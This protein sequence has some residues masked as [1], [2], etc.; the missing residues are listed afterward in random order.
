[1]AGG[2]TGVA[3][4]TR[5]VYAPQ[6][7]FAAPAR[8]TAGLTR[9]ALGFILIE[10]TYA[11]VMH[12]LDAA[13]L[14][15]PL[16]WTDGFYYGTTRLGLIAQLAS[17]GLLGAAVILTVRVL[18]HRGPL[19]LLGRGPGVRQTLYALMAVLALF[20]AIELMP[21]WWSME[22]MTLNNPL[23]WLLLLPLSLGAL[24]VQVASEE[25][26]YR[27]YIQQQLAAR[28]SSPWIWL[29]GPNLLFA[30][31]HWEDGVP[32]TEAAQYAIWAFCFGLAASD[33]TARTGSLGAAV[34]FHLANN[35]YAFLVFGEVGAN[36]SGL[37]LMMFPPMDSLLPPEPVP[38]VTV[39][40]GI[41]LLTLV[42]MWL[43]VRLVLRR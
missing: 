3:M 17:F 27:G 20:T 38:L 23:S 21:P 35:V 37:A 8:P 15:L 42:L 14:P 6:S 9:L 36:D 25:I 11:T 16:D 22:G 18:H 4:L 13:L 33:L 12:L 7:D 28:F 10:A 32:W 30:V 41:E 5:R 39:S 19:S 34:G 26:L 1:M 2:Q 24:T 29:I 43:A 31:A 40:F